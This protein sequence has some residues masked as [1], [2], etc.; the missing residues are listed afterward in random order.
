MKTH[1]FRATGAA[2]GRV[3]FVLVGIVS[4]S[5]LAPAQESEAT[6][7]QLGLAI[8]PVPLN[9]TG[10]DQSMVGLGS[11]FVNV[12]GDCNGCHTGGAAP[13]TSY[14]VGGNPYFSQTAKVDPTVYLSG[15]Q[16]FGPVGTP[17]GPGMYA[18]PDI[19]SRNLTPNYTGMAEGGRT[20]SQ[21]LQEM[22]SGTDLDMLHPTCTPAQ[23]TLIQS[24]ATPPPACIPT[25]S[26]NTANG[27]LLQVMPWP[28]F[29]S[30][31][32]YDL[33]SIYEYLSAIP[34]LEGS[35]DTSSALHNECVA[36]GTTPPPPTT[37]GVTI[38]IVGPGGGT[39]ATNTFQTASGG[40]NLDASQSSSVNAGPLSFAWATAR[41]YP[42]VGISAGNSATPSVELNLPGT[43]QLVLTVTDS[44][45]ATAT[46]TVILQF[47]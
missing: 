19:I 13:N 29:S 24:G 41:G 35:T 7:S 30:L 45:G 42:S 21:F 26:G 39:S 31:T 20:L 16:D 43:Y 37:S 47:I 9:L 23:L 14:A 28:A 32:Q 33:Q 2:A 11:F 40:V 4:I 8:A 15:G 10:K 6:L 44:T 34:C 27:S 12:I 36:T 22:Q 1:S 17:T 18:G 5:Q 3:A 25:S 38:V 46:A